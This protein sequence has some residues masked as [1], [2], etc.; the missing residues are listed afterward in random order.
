M[1]TPIPTP[2]PTDVRREEHNVKRGHDIVD[3]LDVSARRVSYRP[4]VQNPL[5]RSLNLGQQQDEGD[6]EAFVIIARDTLKVWR[7]V[8]RRT[9]NGKRMTGRPRIPESFAAGREEGRRKLGVR[10]TEIK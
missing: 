4:Y 8:R 10:H 3:P 1:I 5:H 9:V 2:A 6:E 7:V